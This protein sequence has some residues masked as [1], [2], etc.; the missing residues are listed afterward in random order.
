MAWYPCLGTDVRSKLAVEAYIRYC[1][2]QLLETSKRADVPRKDSKG[3]HHG[4]SAGTTLSQPTSLEGALHVVVR[5]PQSSYQHT[6]KKTILSDTTKIWRH[7]SEK[8]TK[9][10]TQDSNK[11]LLIYVIF[12]YN[13][14]FWFICCVSP[15]PG[16]PLDKFDYSQNPGLS[17]WSGWA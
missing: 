11:Y 7:K 13:I 8:Q 12:L 15:P 10:Q 3:R 9:S 1:Q 14:V 16:K 4:E 2:K 6:H 5:R 17:F